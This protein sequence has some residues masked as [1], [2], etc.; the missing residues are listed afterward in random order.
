MF[1][2]NSGNRVIFQSREWTVRQIGQYLLN[3]N[4]D[5]RERAVWYNN[6]AD[7][8]RSSDDTQSIFLANLEDFLKS[9]SAFTSNIQ[10]GQAAG[11][12]ASP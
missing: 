7:A 1:P 12:A 8:A 10:K 2:D 5:A 6:F 11:S 3:S 4:H 9:D